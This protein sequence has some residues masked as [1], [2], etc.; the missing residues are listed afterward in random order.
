MKKLFTI[1]FS[2]FLFTGIG[3]A[4]S[5]EVHGNHNATE[6]SE[7]VHGEGDHEVQ[8][9][10]TAHKADGHEVSGTHGDAHGDHH[11][12]EPAAWA[13]IPFVVLLLMIATG[14]LFF[15]HFWHHNYPIVAVVLGGL[16]VGYYIFAL[17]DTGSP[18]SYT[19]LTLP[20]TPYV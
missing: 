5:E 17:G 12:H 19:H 11:A 14:P 2:L 6:V 20:T 16:V 15:E 8:S 3:F 9:D 7:T 10:S 4:E 18:V 1:L 13:V